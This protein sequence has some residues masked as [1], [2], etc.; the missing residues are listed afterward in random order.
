MMFHGAQGT[1]SPAANVFPKLMVKLY[2]ALRAKRYDESLRLSN[3]FAPL[4]AAWAWGSF[5]VVIKEAMTLSGRSSGPPRPPLSGLSHQLQAPFH[6]PLAKH[7]DPVRYIPSNHNLKHPNH[8]PKSPQPPPHPPTL[9]TTATP[10][11]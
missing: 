9:P 10:P 7:A 5:P 8:T 4:R 6:P 3:T 1:V 11:L 2:E